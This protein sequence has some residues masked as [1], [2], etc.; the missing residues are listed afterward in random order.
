M[1]V[2]IWLAS[3]PEAHSALLS[4]GPGPGG[5]LAASAAWTNL[6][7]EYSVAAAELSALLAAVQPGSWQGSSA[8]RC[9]AAH[10]PYLAWLSEATVTSAQVAAQHE[11]AAAAW[12][13]ALASMPTL[14][15][16]AANHAGHAVLVATNFFGINTIPIAL[17]EADYARMW[18][19]A[20][21]TMATYQA[22]TTSVLA[23]SPRYATASPILTAGVG[24]SGA[25]AGLLQTS[26]QAQAAESGVAINLA[27][28][29]AGVLQYYGDTL[30]QMFAPIVEFMQDPLGNFEQLITD[31][32]T[33]PATALVTW[34][35][36][37]Y[38]VGY[39]LFTWPVGSTTWGLIYSSPAW[40]PTLITLGAVGLSELLKLLP[41]PPSPVDALDQMRPSAALAPQPDTTW[42][43]TGAATAPS[44]PITAGSP[45]QVTPGATTATTTPPLAGGE[46]AAYA[47]RGDHPRGGFGPTLHDGT[48]ATVPAPATEATSAAMADSAGD[49]RRARRHRRTAVK[50]RGHRDEYISMAD[51]PAPVFEDTARASTMA[52]PRGAGTVGAAT[53]FA[54]TVTEERVGEAAGLT[55][56]QTGAFGGGTREPMLPH[57]WP[58]P[59]SAPQR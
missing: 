34:W 43:A 39:N 49:K 41:S 31:F 15:E 5:L 52:S 17:N 16:L 8:G 23:T 1:T 35:P 29:I 9:V 57:S 11:T 54:G 21:T 59:D 32:A 46:T 58:P 40:I 36:F 42:P 44:A 7:R 56:L 33:D 25:T 50:D 37:L 28:I 3:P 24:E 47:V 18:I 22:I 26:A 45:A 4:A 12:T 19:Q 38:A 27:D 48:G 13:S 55:R 51:Q 20:A 53:G 6:A 10:F 14:A 2:P 30:N